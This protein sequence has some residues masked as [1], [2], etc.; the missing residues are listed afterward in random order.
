MGKTFILT[1][2]ATLSGVSAERFCCH[3]GSAQRDKDD[4]SGGAILSRP[5]GKDPVSNTGPEEW[6]SERKPPP[7]ES[8]LEA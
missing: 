2:L 7:A 4:G 1:F 6:V 3:A 8:E 5:C